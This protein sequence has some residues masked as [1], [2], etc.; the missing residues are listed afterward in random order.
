MIFV[1]CLKFKNYG[2]LMEEGLSLKVKDN[3]NEFDNII[4]N[5]QNIDINME[6]E[7]QSSS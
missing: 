3:I 4:L 6:Y 5:F 1:G 2:L 7:K